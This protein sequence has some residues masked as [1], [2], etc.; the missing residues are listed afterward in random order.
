M[1]ALCKAGNFM[2]D[3]FTYHFSLFHPSN[4]RN[5]STKHDIYFLNL[6]KSTNLSA[7]PLSL[8]YFQLEFITSLLGGSTSSCRLAA[9]VF[10]GSFFLQSLGLGVSEPEDS[11]LISCITIAQF[12]WN[13]LSEKKWKLFL[14]STLVAFIFSSFL[15]PRSLSTLIVARKC[16]SE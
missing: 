10:W 2:D 16:Y 11:N 15:L 13:L 1:R 12:L 9:V 4:V 8:Q 14:I 5:S 6:I 7:L 3:N